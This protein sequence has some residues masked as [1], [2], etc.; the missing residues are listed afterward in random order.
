MPRNVFVIGLDEPNRALLELLPAARDCTFH[1]LLS[2]EELRGVEHFPIPELLAEAERRLDNFEGSI[3]AI[4]TI[5]DFPATEFVP[6]LARPRGLHTPSLEGVLACNHKYWSRQLQ[7]EAAPEAVPG[8]AILDPYG[9]DPLAATGLEPPIWVKPLNAFRSHLGFRI[10]QPQ[11]L[12]AALP[13]IREELP[14]LA[15]PFES[16]L[17]YAD[18]P[19]RLAELGGKVCIAEQI[20]SGRLCTVEGY[21]QHGVP[22]VY[23]IVDSVRAPNRSSFARYQ[24]PSSLPPP[25][26]RRIVDIAERV[27]TS[28]GLDHSPFNMELFYNARRDTIAVL[29]INPRLSQSHAPLF[30]LVDGVSHLQVMTDVALGRPPEMQSGQ[31]R[32]DIAA[33]FFLRAYRDA[34]V[35]AVPSEQQIARIIERIPGTKI[36]ALVEESTQLSDLED[37]D[38]YSFE[39]AEVYLGARSNRELLAR[40]HAVREELAFGLQDPD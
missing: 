11:D 18:L 27:M 26:Q 7:E 16:V 1:P 14:R 38:A 20:I 3:D 32:Y 10:N 37:Q 19:P 34:R 9:D 25:V 17:K 29:E 12:Y 30:D 22:H 40:W 4:T 13:V 23:G 35:T 33:K 2:F 36:S 21:V 6:L 28:I 24:Y 8:Y 39:L 15:A 31:G 5:I